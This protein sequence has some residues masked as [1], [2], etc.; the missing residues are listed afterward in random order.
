M[1]L[2]IR[3]IAVLALG[4]SINNSFS[5]DKIE[6]VPEEKV[7]TGWNLGGLPVVS[8]DSDLGFQYGALLNLFNYGDG[9]NYPDFNH[10]L[11]LEWS[12]FTKG[13]GINRIFF[14]TKQLIPGIRVT[15]DLSYLTDRM[16]DFF[17]YNGYESVYNAPWTDSEDPDYQSR[18]FY[19][20]DRKLFRFALDLQ[21]KLP[22][23]NLGWAAGIWLLNYKVGPVN[24][25]DLNE[26]KDEADMLPNARSLYDHY[27]GANIISSEE[28]AGSFVSYVKAGVVYDTRDNEP[29]PNRGM[30]TEAVFTYAPSFM[31]I[32]SNYQHM[33]FTLTHR[34]YFT[35][36]PNRLTFAYRL[37][38]QGT[39]FG[40][41]PF[42]LKPNITTLIL[43]GSTSEGLGGGKSL[44]GVIRNR[45]IGDGIAWANLELRWKF[46]KFQFIGQNFYLS[47]NGFV[48]GGMVVSPVSFSKNNDYWSNITWDAEEI[49]FTQSN[50]FSSDKESLHMS[51]GAGLRIVMN[52]NFIIA[53]DHGRPF[54]E[55]DGTSGTY[56]GLN[57]LF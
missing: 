48:D 35:L 15:T 21:G 13:S 3:I 2:T 52:Q 5:Q 14:D 10:N 42:Y 37:G 9:S 45:V 40:D 7:K 39:V 51:Y 6:T 20:H 24:I 31:G 8:F 19:K 29:N 54:D 38:Y 26:G 47:L 23:E 25:G 46:I 1:R 33:K 4:L 12:R 30:W 56:I 27:V 11:Y 22:I 53:I 34:Q 36:S 43:R 28:A 57:F 41:V 16:Y 50:I 17:G 49:L 55:R 32:G 18:A 44:R